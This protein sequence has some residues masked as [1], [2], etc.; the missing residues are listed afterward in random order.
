M[1][2]DPVPVIVQFP[3]RGE[4]WVA[5]NSPGDRV[6]S[7][8]TDMLGQRYAY[9]FLQVDTRRGVK[10]HPG[11]T[12]GSILFGYPTEAAYAWGATIHA[13][14]SG[15]I[16]ATG[17]G[18]TEP[19]RV[20]PLGAIGRAIKVGATFTPDKLSDVLGN[21]ILMRSGDVYAGFAHLVPG[22]VRVAKG[23]R[24]DIGAP[25]G[26]LG[27]TGNSTAPHL[28]FQLM[29]SP[30][31]LTANGVPCAFEFYEE[32]RGADWVGVRGGIPKRADRV[33]FLG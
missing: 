7:H 8:G 19:S 33:R 23:D 6:P 18:V 28:H 17:D 16:V 31:L 29:D 32:L 1:A 20:D 12:V 21:F 15:E 10:N 30:D 9:D 2:Q 4:R 11:G 26:K 24:V 5:V 14:L 13:P 27:H 22:S 25:I 3:L